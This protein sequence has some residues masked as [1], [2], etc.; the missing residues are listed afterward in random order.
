MTVFDASRIAARATAPPDG[1][2]ALSADDLLH[3]RFAISALG[4][5]VEAA[6]A[7]G[8]ASS[9]GASTRWLSRERSTLRRLANAYDLRP[10]VALLP[11]DGL[12]PSF[13]RPI[14]QRPLAT[15]DTEIEAVRRTP[16]EV[17]V[18]EVERVLRGR[19]IAPA[20][21][22]ALRSDAAAS[23]IAELLSAL[24]VGLI[25]PRWSA[26]QACLERDI[27]FRSRVVA[28]KGLAVV[29][30]DLGGPAL[31]EVER[32]SSSTEGRGIVF[33]PSVF[34]GAK[35]HRSAAR[36]REPRLVRYRARGSEAIWFSSP[37]PS[38]E[39]LASL[40]GGTRAKILQALREPTATTN[41]ARQLGRSPGNIA[42]HLAVLRTSGLVRGARLGSYVL[43]SRTALGDALARSVA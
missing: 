1:L 32:A 35:Q 43:Y 36:H 12:T 8:V 41:L 10:L 22:R 24:W 9:Q 11:P 18:D 4:E 39:A 40:I 3:C 38:P 31:F 17:V 16:R 27:L 29:M 20:V 25:L 30:H 33:V 23:R 34:F 19:M 42:D 28:T 21:E 26:I 5:V 2:R 14:P 7:I 15:F 13:L 37:T 6:R